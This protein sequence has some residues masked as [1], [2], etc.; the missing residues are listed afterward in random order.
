MQNDKH[1]TVLIYY[2]S[3]HENERTYFLTIKKYSRPFKT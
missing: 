1:K 2:G 3:N